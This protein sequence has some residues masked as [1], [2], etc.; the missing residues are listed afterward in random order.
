MR[1]TAWMA[2]LLAALATLQ[3]LAVLNPDRVEVDPEEMYNAAHAYALT[4][5]HWRDAFLLQYRPFCGGCTLDAALGAGVFALLPPTWLAWKVVPTLFLLALAVAATGT[6]AR[7]EGRAPALAMGLL[8]LLPPPAFADLA[9][10]A[11]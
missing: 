4:R 6:L 1:R 11:W 8:L 7:R 5:G 3:L 2:A 10:I 9:L